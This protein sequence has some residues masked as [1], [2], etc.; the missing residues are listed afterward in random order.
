MRNAEFKAV[1][2]NCPPGEML[3]WEH[4]ALRDRYFIIR[5]PCPTRP[6]TG[7]SNPNNLGAVQLRRRK[8][9]YGA[10]ESRCHVPF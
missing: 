4:T 10:R 5:E 3:R 6:S 2:P 1:V 8:E 9:D 7:V